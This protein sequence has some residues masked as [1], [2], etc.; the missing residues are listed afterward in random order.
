MAAHRRR[1]R[2]AGAEPSRI[3]P[4]SEAGA[5]SLLESARRADRDGG[6]PRATP[7]PEHRSPERRRLLLRIH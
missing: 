3:G 4:G 2:C 5:R 6:R 7:N 1:R